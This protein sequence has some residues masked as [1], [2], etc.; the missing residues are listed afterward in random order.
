MGQE[1]ITLDPPDLDQC[2]ALKPNGNNA[3]T[4]GDKPG[5]IQCEEKPSVIVT[6]NQPGDDGLIGSMSL[7][8]DCLDAFNKQKGPGF[9]TVSV[10]KEKE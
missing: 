2:Q 8:A 6:E 3:F 5:L 4:L 1:Q 10:I 7:C 9:A